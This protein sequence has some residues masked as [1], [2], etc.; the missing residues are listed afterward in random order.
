MSHFHALGSPVL[1]AFQKLRL[2]VEIEK[3]PDLM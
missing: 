2:S 3:N 1:L